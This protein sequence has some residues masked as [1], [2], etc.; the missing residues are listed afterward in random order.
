MSLVKSGVEVFIGLGSN[1]GS[2]LEHI[3]NARLAINDLSEVEEIGFSPL[4]SSSPVGPQDQP[5]YVNAVMHVKTSL[6]ATDLLKELQGIE[7][8]H[9]RERLVRWGARTLDLDILLYGQQTISEYNLQIPHPE[10][11]K[12]AFVLYPLADIAD[13]ELVV[14]G[15]GRLNELLSACPAVGLF[16][17]EQ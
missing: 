2:P 11:P 1:L 13:P 9:G 6:S 7:N 4:Y 8:S 15:M 16:R 14:P 17:M 5:D 12:R 10:L 3:H